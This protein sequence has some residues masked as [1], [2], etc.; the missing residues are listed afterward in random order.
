MHFFYYFNYQLI[1]GNV[2]HPPDNIYFIKAG[3]CKIVREVTLIQSKTPY[4]KVKVSLP[5]L[6]EKHDVIEGFE[7]QNSQKFIKK[8]LHIATIGKG[9]F[10]GVGELEKD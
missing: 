2:E 9:S 1:L 5:P 10:F 7:L 3:E 6:N 8:F 4:G